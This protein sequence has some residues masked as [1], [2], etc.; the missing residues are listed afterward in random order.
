MCCTPGRPH[1]EAVSENEAIAELRRHAGKQ[2]DVRMVEALDQFDSAS[3]VMEAA[4]ANQPDERMPMGGKD[5]PVTM[6]AEPGW[7]RLRPLT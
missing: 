5:A 7:M 1:R 4:A 2:F 6:K 3:A